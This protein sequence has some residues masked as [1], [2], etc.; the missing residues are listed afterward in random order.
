ML[1]HLNFYFDKWST[2]DFEHSLFPNKQIKFK[3]KKNNIYTRTNI[4]GYPMKSGRTIPPKKLW[5]RNTESNIY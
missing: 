2:D 1:I 4:Y 3:K 5:S